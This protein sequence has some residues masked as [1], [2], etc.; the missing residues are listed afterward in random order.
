MT[1]KWYFLTDDNNWAPLSSEDNQIVENSYLNG[2][3]TSLIGLKEGAPSLIRFDQMRIYNEI[4]GHGR[5][6]RRKRI[7]NAPDISNEKKVMLL[8][9]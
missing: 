2:S 5:T 3:S 7:E 8:F 6:V 1:Y 4:T 9:V